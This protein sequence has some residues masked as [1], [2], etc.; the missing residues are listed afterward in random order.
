M[1]P[2]KVFLPVVTLLSSCGFDGTSTRD[3]AATSEMALSSVSTV[4][5]ATGDFTPTAVNTAPYM[6]V[7]SAKVQL[8]HDGSLS[9]FMELAGAL[10]DTPTEPQ[11]IWPFHVDTDPSAAP[12]GLYVDYIV[13]VLWTGS[14]YVGQVVHRFTTTGG[15]VGLTV[16]SV[17]F[18][19]H[20][21][22][23][24]LTVDPTLLGSPSS[25]GW[26]A[27]TRPGAA[28]PYSDFAPNCLTCLVT[29]SAK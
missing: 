14:A 4:T 12:G 9:F 11:L 23:V 6:D 3:E 5:D 28:N 25:F 10:P 16:T 2:L 27:A 24:A 17:P 19:I 18:V 8:K 22:T 7:V 13:R 26:N 21:A 29:W 15:G 20:G 1:K